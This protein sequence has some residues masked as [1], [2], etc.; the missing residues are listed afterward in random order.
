M[1]RSGRRFR[2][3]FTTDMHWFPQLLV[4]RRKAACRLSRHFCPNRHDGTTKRQKKSEQRRRGTH[5]YENIL[6]GSIP[7]LPEPGYQDSLP[8]PRKVPIKSNRNFP[9][10]KSK[11]HPKR[12]PDWKKRMNLPVVCGLRESLCR[13][14]VRALGKVLEME[15][16]PAPLGL[17]LS[18]FAK[19]VAR[20]RTAASFASL[21]RRHKRGALELRICRA[22][23]VL[24]IENGLI[25]GAVRATLRKGANR[26]DSEPYYVGADTS[27]EMAHRVMSLRCNDLW[28]FGVK[29]LSRPGEF[30]SSRPIRYRNPSTSATCGSP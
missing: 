28:A 29:R 21:A 16:G 3:H 20:F 7:N 26:V 19:N 27:Q 18:T 17:A 9:L 23:T 1:A 8:L 15:L 12:R 6:Q 2:F 14:G 4:P 13:N 10:L 11:S 22:R 5:I 30:M 25:V 24:D